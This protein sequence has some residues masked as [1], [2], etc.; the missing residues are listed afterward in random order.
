MLVDRQVTKIYFL[1]FFVTVDD[2]VCTYSLFFFHLFLVLLEGILTLQSRPHL[3]SYLDDSLL[4]E[5]L[6]YP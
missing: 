2:L 1:L 5:S 4:V 6:A 3:A